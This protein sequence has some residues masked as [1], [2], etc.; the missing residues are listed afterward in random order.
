MKTYVHFVIISRSVLLHV[1]N[2][3]DNSCTENALYAQKLSFENHTIYEYKKNT[4]EQAHA[5][6]ILDN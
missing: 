1:R 2:V 3:S 6:C 4:A 5:Y